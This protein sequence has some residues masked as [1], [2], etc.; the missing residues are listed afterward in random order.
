MRTLCQQLRNYADTDSE[1]IF[2]KKLKD[3]KQIVNEWTNLDVLSL[4][5]I[6][7]VHIDDVTSKLRDAWLII[8]FK[9]Y[10]NLFT[11]IFFSLYAFDPE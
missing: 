5:L 8:F 3:Q 2:L 9:N 4:T 6:C 10:E 1:Y 11:P 7:K